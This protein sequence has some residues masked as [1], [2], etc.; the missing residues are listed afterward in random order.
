MDGKILSCVVLAITSILL[1]FVAA[2]IK[3]ERLKV[4]GKVCFDSD[5]EEAD[6]KYERRR[7]LQY[8]ACVLSFLCGYTYGILWGLI[9][10]FIAIL[11][12]KMISFL[13]EYKS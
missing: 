10:T 13:I 12:I 4:N 9:T 7:F 3:D 1:I 2:R 5:N 8:L 6:S 11:V